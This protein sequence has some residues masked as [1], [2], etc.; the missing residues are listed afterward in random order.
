MQYCNSDEDLFTALCCSFSSF[1]ACVY[2]IRV[3]QCIGCHVI[4]VFIDIH[5]PVQ[6]RGY[7]ITV[8]YEPY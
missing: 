3:V 4:I 5:T 1:T 8:G 2:I 7:V 6:Y